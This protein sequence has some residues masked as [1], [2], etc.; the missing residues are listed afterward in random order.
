MLYGYVLI[1]HVKDFIDAITEG[2]IFRFTKFL[3]FSKSVI[4]PP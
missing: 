2:V 4:I 1:I 3:K